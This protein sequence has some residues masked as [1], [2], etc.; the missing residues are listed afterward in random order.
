MVYVILLNWNGWKDT[1]HC[2]ESLFRSDYSDYRVIVC[3]NASTDG[4]M[5]KIKAWAEGKVM[6]DEELNDQL[7]P[8]V[9]PPVAKPIAYVEYNRA[10]AE[11]GGN[12]SEKNTP[13]VLIQ[14]GSNDGFSAG[15]NVGIRYALK[16]NADYIWLLNNDTVV[17]G[18]T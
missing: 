4:S 17:K 12:G 5:E 18:N 16:K 14:N 9:F 13:L 2:L 8:L 15:N 7:K 10:E 11:A 3:D 1:I 6:P